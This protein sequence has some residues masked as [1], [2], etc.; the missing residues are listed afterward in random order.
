MQAVRPCCTGHPS[1]PGL[2]S[3]RPSRL[4]PSPLPR[5]GSLRTVRQLLGRLPSSPSKMAGGEAGVTLGQP[6]L[7]RQ[8][9][10]TLVRFRS[11]KMRSELRSGND[12]A[13][14]EELRRGNAGLS[15]AWL[16]PEPS[17]LSRATAAV[18]TSATPRAGQRGVRSWDREIMLNIIKIFTFEDLGRECLHSPQC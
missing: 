15:R 6:H 14:R 1:F 7:S 8:D 9:L 13:S 12:R 17:A 11:E 16:A 4:R 18:C 5:T 3:S 2:G 10:A